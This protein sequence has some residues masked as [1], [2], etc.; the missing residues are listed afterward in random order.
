MYL[1]IEVDTK[2]KNFTYTLTLALLTIL[3][4]SL[5]STTKILI[6]PPY[7]CTQ[8]NFLNLSSFPSQQLHCRN[9]AIHGIIPFN[10]IFCRK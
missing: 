1:S 9:E 7:K 4:Y 6:I 3:L 10:F 2:H 8:T 5:L